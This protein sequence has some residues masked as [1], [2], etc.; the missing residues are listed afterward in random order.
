[1]KEVILIKL[2][3]LVLKGLNRNKFEDLLLKNIRSSMKKYGTAKVK[4][5]QSTVYVEFEEE[6]VDMDSVLN[7]CARIFCIVTVV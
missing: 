3:E 6:D 5:A 2:G 1:M 4:A 7:S